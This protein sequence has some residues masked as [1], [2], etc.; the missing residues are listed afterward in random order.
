MDV[1]KLISNIQKPWDGIEAPAAHFARGD[2]YQRQ[3]LKVGQ[4]KK[5]QLRLAFALATFQLAGEFESALREW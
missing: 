5:P 3:L 4:Q 2:K 1:T